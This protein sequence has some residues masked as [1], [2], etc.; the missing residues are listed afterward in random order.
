MLTK[1]I[2]EQISFAYPKPKGGSK[3]SQKGGNKR[4]EAPQGDIVSEPLQP[5]GIDSADNK[6]IKLRTTAIQRQGSGRFAGKGRTSTPATLRYV[7]SSLFVGASMQMLHY[8]CWGMSGGIGC[9]QQEARWICWLREHTTRGIELPV[10][11]SAHTPTNM[12]T[13]STY[14]AL[15]L[16]A[17]PA[18]QGYKRPCSTHLS[19]RSR[20]PIQP[21]RLLTFSL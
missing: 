2:T 19:T 13:R 3:T 8:W 4:T 12:K 9:R 15:V 11:R 5:T 21:W 17:R 7:L 20:Q 1:A 10:L 18:K 6:G 14:K 16:K